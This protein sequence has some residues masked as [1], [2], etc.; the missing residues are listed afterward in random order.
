MSIKELDSPI[1]LPGRTISKFRVNF[2]S[3]SICSLEADGVTEVGH[4]PLDLKEED[5]EADDA[6]RVELERVAAAHL[7]TLTE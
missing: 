4:D 3:I 1:E 6:L 2:N 7:Q 5:L